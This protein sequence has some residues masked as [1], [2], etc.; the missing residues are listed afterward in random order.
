MKEPLPNNGD[1]GGAK[2]VYVV[3]TPQWHRAFG[4]TGTL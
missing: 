2:A 4:V 3:Q 1:R